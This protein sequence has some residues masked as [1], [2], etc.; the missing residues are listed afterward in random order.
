MKIWFIHE[1]NILHIEPRLRRDLNLNGYNF[2][3]YH[4][5]GN[6][7]IVENCYCLIDCKVDSLLQSITFINLISKEPPNKILEIEKINLCLKEILG[8][9]DKKISKILPPE[10]VFID[11][12]TWNFLID[13][14]HLKEY[15]L[16]L[17]PAGCGKTTISYALAKATNRDFYRLNGGGLS[18]PKS[19]LVGTVQALNGSTNLIESEF[20]KFYRS[21]K[22]TLI[23]IDEISRM[24]GAASNYT[25][26]MLEGFNS[27]IYVEEL[28]ERIYK[29]ENVTFI[30]AGNFGIE[31]T[32]TRKLDDAFKDR[33][34]PYI[35]DYLPVEQEIKCIIKNTNCSEN[36]AKVL[37][38]IGGIFRAEYET[39]QTKISTRKLISLAKYSTLGYSLKDITEVLIFN[40]FVNGSIDNRIAAKQILNSKM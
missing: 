7:E 23:M 21:E 10:D 6:L 28:G 40:L 30:G 18:K 8:V 34:N 14:I 24:S 20:L 35:F 27:Y 5:V 19:T 25:M 36:I 3:N 29:G 12:K 17:G 2:E 9:Q 4:L 37:V 11:E 31:Y 38:K 15:P 13:S 33:F 16:L 22:P 26:T 39:L 1:N 32:E